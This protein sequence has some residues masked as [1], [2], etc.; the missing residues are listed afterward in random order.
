MKQHERTH[1]AGSRAGSAGASPVIDNK[2]GG[3]KGSMTSS[4]A[5]DVDEM[6]LGI[7]GLVPRRP[8]MA[9]SELSEIMEGISKGN[10][11]EGN[12]ADM[13]ADG[14]GESPGLDALAT[15][16]SEMV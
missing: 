10:A 2:G 5:M 3:R 6:G 1:K 8:K 16:A 4:D 12:E 11:I 14:E 15:A 7:G 9:R 13:D